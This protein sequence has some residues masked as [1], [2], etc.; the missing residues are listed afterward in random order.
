MSQPAE[1]QSHRSKDFSLSPPQRKTKVFTTEILV[2]VR[3]ALVALA[4]GL[5]PPLISA[6][7]AGD[8]WV[9]LFFQIFVWITLAVS[10][11]FFSG[12]SGYSSFGHGAFYGIG[13]YTTATLMVQAKLP[14]LVALPVAGLG[15]ALVA[16]LVG[17]IVFRLPQLRGELF[18]LL[19]LALTFI[20][21]TI[22]NNVAWIDGGSGVFL[23][24][25]TADRFGVE[26]NRGLYYVSLGIALAAVGVAYGIFHGRW[27]QA[28]FAIRDD[29]D[30]ADGLGVPTFRYKVATFGLSALFAGLIGGAQALFLGYLEAGHVFAV[31]TPLLALMMAILG[32]ATVWYGPILGAVLI[33]LLRQWLTGGDTAALNQMVIGLV[34]VLVILFV[35]QGIGGLIEERRR[36]RRLSLAPAPAALTAEGG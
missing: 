7:G 28:L 22:V 32:G 5:Y 20:I 18:S 12:Y 10:W 34:L 23:R 24:A 25:A 1:R 30:G 15:A 29:E 3:F 4:L 27:G 13:M 35:P 26:D 14:F 19:T 17:V 2:G 9:T 16:L 6:L 36:Q 21:A 33:T 11:N 8:F 31:I